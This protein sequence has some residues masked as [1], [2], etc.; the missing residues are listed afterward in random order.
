MYFIICIF[1]PHFKLMIFYNL[2]HQ[3]NYIFLSI[4]SLSNPFVK[5]LKIKNITAGNRTKTHTHIWSYDHLTISSYMKWNGMQNICYQR[6]IFFLQRLIIQAL[7]TKNQFIFVYFFYR[8]Y[9][10]I[11]EIINISKIKQYEFIHLIFFIF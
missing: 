3:I 9:V 1:T 11:Y 5:S 2:N 7:V 4:Q 8:K 6:A 10:Y